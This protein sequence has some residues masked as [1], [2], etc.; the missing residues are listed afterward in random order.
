[1]TVLAVRVGDLQEVSGRGWVCRNHK[2]LFLEAGDFPKNN[3]SVLEAKYFVPYLARPPFW[4]EDRV[5]LAQTH[6]LVQRHWA[7]GRL[8]PPHSQ[9]S[10]VG[11]FWVKVS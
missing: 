2:G 5:G 4:K 9:F 1:V 11:T 10:G 3:Q 6:F 7:S 8:P